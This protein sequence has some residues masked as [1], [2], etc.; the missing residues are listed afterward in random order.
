LSDPS[1]VGIPISRAILLPPGTFG[2]GLRPILAAIDLVHGDGNL[3]QITVVT[4]PSLADAASYRR[5]EPWGIP[6]DIAVRPDAPHPG[7][8][9]VHEIGHFLDHQSIGQP[10]VFASPDDQ[11]VE[12]WRHAIGI[13]QAV[14]TLQLVE[15]RTRS[16]RVL[17]FVRYQ[18]RPV[19][20]WARSYAQFIAMESEQY[21]LLDE[22]HQRQRAVTASGVPVQWSDDDFLPVATSIA[23]LF[24]TLE[25][26]A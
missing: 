2:E 21:T 24:R 23:D 4:E 25:W 14:M 7:L 17:E 12:R 26:M 16:P 5:V 8:N 15:Q 10:G 19:E 11:R 6:W 1:P 9:L 18:L 22:L 13:T 20:L 3:P